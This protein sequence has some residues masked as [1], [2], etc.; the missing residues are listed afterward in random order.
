[1]VLL[2]LLEI[3]LERVIRERELEIK[4][5]RIRDRDMMD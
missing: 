5:E 3:E 4:L 2:E 1:L